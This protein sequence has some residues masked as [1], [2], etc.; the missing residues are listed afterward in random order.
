MSELTAGVAR[1]D[2]TPPCGLPHG[3]WA[4]RTGLAEGVHDPLVAQALVLDDG[5]T[6]VAIVALDLVFA[7]A[8]LTA[9]VRER[10]QRLTG[11]PP[12]AVLVNAAHNHSAPSLSRGCS[13][14]GLRDAPAFA[15]YV[16][17][18][19]ETIAGVVY[20]AWRSLAPARVGSALGSVPGV[21]VNRVVPERPVDDTVGVVAVDRADGSPLAVV[22]SFACHPDPDGRPDAALERRL[23]GA[24]ARDGAA[25]RGRAPSASSSRAAA[26][27]SPAG[28]TGSATGR[29][30][31]HSYAR[32]DELGEAIGA[33]VARGARR[34]RD[35]AP[36]CGSARRR[37][38][39]S[40]AAAATPYALEDLEARLAELEAIPVP[41]FPEAWDDSVH[42]ATSAQQFPPMYQ[43]SALAFYEDMV[44]RADVPV[45]AELQALAIGD[46]AIVANPF[47]LFNECGARDPRAQPVRH[48][49]RRSGTRTTTP[50]TSP[51]TRTST[52]SR[53][54]RS[55]RSSTRTATAGPTGSRTRTSTAASIGRADRRERRAAR[56][57]AGCVVKITAVETHVCNARMRNWVFVKVVT[58][59][60]GLVRLGR[61][62]AR[63]A[64]ARGRRA[65]SRTSPS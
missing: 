12:H 57:P 64:H 37:A 47:E 34:D 45:R 49:A 8:D 21:T 63:V 31:R 56:E 3:C 42:T 10:V 27:T 58:D 14:A 11:I 46:A 1:A 60:P 29:R 38:R 32:R 65:R 41:D 51:P 25:R 13:V 53:A 4:L 6:T 23:P 36:T 43:R 48:D 24:A 22:A 44:E 55:T 18:L 9:A 5:E 28:T 17:L 26:A 50:A 15:A 54:S 2:I 7:G 33:A 52:S 16:E 62:D 39:S 20:A 61:G 19:P 40:C 30:R 35:D 59:Q